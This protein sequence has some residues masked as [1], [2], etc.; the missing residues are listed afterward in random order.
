MDPIL[1]FEQLEVSFPEG[2]VVSDITFQL[3]KGEILGLVGES[4]SGKSTIIKAAMGIM[5][6]GGR[7]TN[8]SIIYQDTNLVELSE[9]KMNTLRGSQL[10]MIFQDA[11]GSLCPIRTIG[12]QILECM[13]V[14]GKAARKQVKEEAISLFDKLNFKGSEKIW[15]SYPF[16][17]SGG[18]NQRVAV[19]ITMLMKPK[20]LLADEPTSALDNISRNQVLAE[21]INI[22]D[23]GTSVILVT[24]DIDIVDA[25]CDRVVVLKD[26]QIK[27]WGEAKEVLRAPKNEY[28]K[29]LI[30]STRELRGESLWQA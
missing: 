19:A 20:I 10:G 5:N 8:G 2:P 3:K 16:E 28:T 14:R 22:N 12:D 4:G 23:M 1:S 9:K 18:M 30:N 7:I 17:L 24:H 6:P 27:E 13:K 15:N 11:G 26:G 25:I 29:L 21:L